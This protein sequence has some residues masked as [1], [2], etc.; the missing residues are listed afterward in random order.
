MLSLNSVTKSYGQ[1][2][3]FRGISLHIGVHDRIALLGSNGAGK[4]TLLDILAGDLSPDEGS[5]TRRK[6][7]SIGYLRQ[8]INNQSEQP[9][10]SE[11]T[12]AAISINSLTH[13]IQIIQEELAEIP[14]GEEANR[15]ISEMGEL[16]H[17]F[18]AK[19]GYDLDYEARVILFGLGFKEKDLQKPL[20]HFSGGWIVRAELAKTLLMNPDNLLMDEPTNHLDMETQMW[21]EDY[22]DNYHGSVLLT[23]H[24]RSFLNR[25]ANRILIIENGKGTLY[26]GNYNDYIIAHNQEMKILQ[27]T[28]ARQ[29]AQIEK[30]THFIE[31]FRYKATKASQVQ[32]RIKMLARIEKVEI[33][34]QSR[35]IHFD[36]PE[37]PRSGYEVIH[38]KHIYK[39]YG[40]NV[41]YRNLNL[42]LHRGDRVALIGPNGAG[43]TTLLKILAGILPFEQGE[44]KPGYNVTTAYYAQH[45][46]EL[47]DPRLSVIEELSRVS[48]PDF[49]EQ[50]IRTILGGFLFKGDDVLK[51]ISIL[52]GGEKARLAL[53]KMLIRPASFLLMDEPTNHLDIASREILTDALEAYKGTLCFIT[54][55]RTLIRQTANQI[56]EVKDGGIAIFPGDYDS[57]LYHRQESMSKESVESQTTGKDVIPAAVTN[58]RQRRSEIGELRSKYYEQSKPIKERLAHIEAETTQMETRLKA[59]EQELACPEKYQHSERVVECLKCHRELKESIKQ[60]TAEWEELSQEADRLKQE[61]DKA[62]ATYQED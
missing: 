36:F 9:L 48:L 30:D 33:P 37:P 8:E 51:S 57:Y 25:V 14:P 22:L 16:Q 10:I 59:L 58:Q 46:L 27:A 17:L 31:R 40:D 35:K 41:V 42:V 60:L 18:E 6:N 39:A 45:Q 7:I 32:S 52:S 15:L 47:L 50:Q 56:V 61:F 1:R 20:S 3:L 4:T 5:I 44:R 54:H 2:T 53:A 28:A 62:I 38:L 55:D 12:S 13:R 34:R 24:D 19:R 11:V 49:T 26:A 43:K 29:A 23:S 21:F